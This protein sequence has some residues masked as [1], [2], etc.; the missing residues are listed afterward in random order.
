MLSNQLAH[1]VGRQRPALL[2]SI[3]DSLCALQARDCSTYSVVNLCPFYVLSRRLRNLARSPTTPAISRDLAQRRVLDGGM[4]HLPPPTLAD[5]RGGLS[6]SLLSLLKSLPTTTTATATTTAT[7][8][9]AAAGGEGDGG[10]GSGD[11]ADAGG[12]AALE[13]ALA[14][15][16]IALGGTEQ[17][18]R[19]ISPRYIAEIRPLAKLLN[20]SGDVSP[21]VIT[22]QRRYVS[23]TYPM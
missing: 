1:A 7:T 11:G 17:A 6:S 10:G 12:I 4:A 19:D 5:V 23:V 14:G 9:I 3:V 20:G 18:R 13:A 15:S 16:L 8:T 21:D 2:P 22:R